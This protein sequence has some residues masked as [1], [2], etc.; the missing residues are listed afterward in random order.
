MFN[1]TVVPAQSD[2]DVMFCLQSIMDLEPTDHLFINPIPMVTINTQAIFR[3]LL[4]QVK[5]TR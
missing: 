4:A 3:F 1:L 5:C 2:K